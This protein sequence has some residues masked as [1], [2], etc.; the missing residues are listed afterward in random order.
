MSDCEPGK[1]TETQSKIR[2]KPNTKEKKEIIY[3]SMFN[4]F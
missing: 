4:R 1:E 3:E 2:Q